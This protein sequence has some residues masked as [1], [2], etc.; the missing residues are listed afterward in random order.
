[1]DNV[2]LQNMLS[3]NGAEVKLHILEEGPEADD[4]TVTLIKQAKYLLR[5]GWS[6][7]AKA[8]DYKTGD[9]IGLLWDKSSGRVLLHHIK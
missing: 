5:A 4:Y 6:N 7:I 8:K 9:E 3:T 2:R 1:M